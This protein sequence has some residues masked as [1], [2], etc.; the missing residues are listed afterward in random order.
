MFELGAQRDRVGDLVLVDAPGNRLEDAPMH[1]VGEVLGGEEL[2]DPFIGAVIGH[3]RAEQRL[4]GGHIIG[5]GALGQAQQV[6]FG[7][8]VHPRVVAQ[9]NGPVSR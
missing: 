8:A 5:G 6:L 3:Q 2:A 7:D 1:G 9:P 4:F